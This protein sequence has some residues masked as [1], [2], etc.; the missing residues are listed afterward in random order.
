MP[1]KLLMSRKTFQ[2]STSPCRW[3]R[4]LCCRSASSLEGWRLRGIL[5]SAALFGNS[6]PRLFMLS[7]PDSK[8]TTGGKTY[9]FEATVGH[10]GGGA[11]WHLVHTE[12]FAHSDTTTHLYT[13]FH[14]N[15]RISSLF[16]LRTKFFYYL[17]GASW[18]KK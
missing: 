15:I 17:H 18:H 12:H 7:T 10:H 1:N 8:H 3:W 6:A 13:N 16:F 5:K 2:G 9:G 4:S 14:I 11:A